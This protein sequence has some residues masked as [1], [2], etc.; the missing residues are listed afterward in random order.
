M[1]I[2]KIKILALPLDADLKIGHRYQGGSKREGESVEILAF[3]NSKH[4]SNNHIEFTS[5]STKSRERDEG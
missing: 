2:A 4:K 1:G 3:L 5:L